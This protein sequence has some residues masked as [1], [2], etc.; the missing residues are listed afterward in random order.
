MRLVDDLMEPFRP[1]VDLL[2]WQLQQ[3]GE[4]QVNP[5]TKRALVRSLYDD[6]QTSSGATPAMVCMQ[7]LAVSLAQIYLGE[8]DK[9]DLPFPGLPLFL[10]ANLADE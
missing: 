3:R 7:R 2:V 6:M 9:L 5:E 4:S 8:R 10:S 1:V